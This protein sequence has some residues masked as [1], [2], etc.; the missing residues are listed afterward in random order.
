MTDTCVTPVFT[1][2]IVGSLIPNSSSDCNC[3]SAL[4]CL[5]FNLDAGVHLTGTY[6]LV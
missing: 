3:T 5:N 4:L 2:E 1:D 6:C